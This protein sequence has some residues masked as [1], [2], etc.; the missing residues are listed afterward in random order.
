MH[1]MPSFSVLDARCNKVTR[2]GQS[3]AQSV[4]PSSALLEY[5]YGCEGAAEHMQAHHYYACFAH[6]H[7]QLF[8]T[9]PEPRAREGLSMS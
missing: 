6:A 3:A 7:H 2:Q 1:V 9:R 8:L 5:E 4:L